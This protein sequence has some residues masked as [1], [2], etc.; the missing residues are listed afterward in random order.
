MFKSLL[1]AGLFALGL[2]ATS[3]TADPLRFIM[4][5]HSPESDTYWISVSKGL[6][7]AGKD[8]GVSVQYRGTDKNLNDPNQQ[9]RNLE[10]AIASKPDG[11]IVSDPTPASLNETIKKATDAGIPVILVNQGGEQVEKVGALAF[12]GDEPSHQGV[13]GA[14]QFNAIGAKHALVITTPMGAIPF[15][16]ARTNGFTKTFKGSSALAE[17]PLPD[18]S[19]SNR[20]KTITETLLQK[21]PSIDAV[22]SIGSAFIAAMEQVRADLGDRGAAMHWGTIDVTAG[23]IIALKAHKLDFALDAQ[24]Y[25]QGYYP[26]VMLALY[27]RQAIQPA[28]PVFVTGP[29]IVTPDNVAR[30]SAAVR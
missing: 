5:T 18:A 23:A 21:D 24:Q 15:V 16:D 10:A 22:F 30:V 13:L 6:E 29:A 8:L 27:A 11:L 4:V 3:A 17:I 9:R 26:V 2:S 28:T 25:A 14:E 1:L 12:V 20:V 7:Q 19:D